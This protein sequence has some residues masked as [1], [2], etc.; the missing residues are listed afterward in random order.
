MYGK[1]RSI[2]F[3]PLL[4]S[5]VSLLLVNLDDMH[6][7]STNGKC[8]KEPTEVRNTVYGVIVT[9]VSTLIL[10]YYQTLL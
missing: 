4:F 6:G 5:D 8:M 10:E 7:R 1:L 9:P 3:V 2:K